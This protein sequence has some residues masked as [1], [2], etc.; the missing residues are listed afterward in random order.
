MIFHAGH[1]NDGRLPEQS[2]DKSGACKR[3]HF[4]V[5]WNIRPLR[6]RPGTGFH[7]DGDSSKISALSDLVG[8]KLFQDSISPLIPNLKH[9]AI[10]NV[11]G[12][13][14]R[15]VPCLQG[16]RPC[17]SCGS[18]RLP[19]DARCPPA[20]RAAQ[21]EAREGHWYTAGCSQAILPGNWR[22]RPVVTTVQPSVHRFGQACSLRGRVSDQARR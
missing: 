5:L 22:N 11:S 4:R 20:P 8:G 19:G 17:L 14:G 1:F 10:S 9:N 13:Q 7:S 21:R 3:G 16:K 12:C 15:I 6:M 2:C 18:G